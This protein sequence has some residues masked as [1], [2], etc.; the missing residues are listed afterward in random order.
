MLPLGLMNQ[1]H[2]FFFRLTWNIC[3]FVH[4]GS[5]AFIWSRFD[6]FVLKRIFILIL[7]K[8]LLTCTLYRSYFTNRIV[9]LVL[10]QPKILFET[11]LKNNVSI[12]I[13]ELNVQ[14]KK[15]LYSWRYTYYLLLYLNTLMRYKFSSPS[16]RQFL[17][18]DYTICP[19]NM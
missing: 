8:N 12:R 7:Y 3:L 5:V 18:L 4:K 2:G 16:R 6:V 9:R 10:D 14:V 1:F 11:L 13:V 17:C 15:E 19:F